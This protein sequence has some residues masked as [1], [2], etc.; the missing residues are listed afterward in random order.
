[1]SGEQHLGWEALERVRT[2]EAS[3]DEFAHLAK[4]AACRE[5]L[6][7]LERLASRFKESLGAEADAIPASREDAILSAAR[8]RAAAIAGKKLV[9]L[10]WWRQRST[11]AIA[12][13]LMVAGSAAYLTYFKGDEPSPRPV[14]TPAT[15]N[16]VE[17]RAQSGAQADHVSLRSE[18]RARTDEDA[19]P[20]KEAALLDDRP[21]AAPQELQK[22]VPSAALLPSAKPVEVPQAAA[23]PKVGVDFF[24]GKRDEA[25]SKDAKL[26]ARDSGAA[27]PAMRAPVP[28]PAKSAPAAPPAAIAD[29]RVRALADEAPAPAGSALGGAAA[30]VAGPARQAPAPPPPAA[31]EDKLVGALSAREEGAERRIAWLPP[32]TGLWVRGQGDERD[33]LE[34]QPLQLVST[35]IEVR[36]GD[37]VARRV[38]QR[39]TNPSGQP[40][41]ATYSTGLAPGESS[42]Q[43]SLKIGNS[44]VPPQPADEMTHLRVWQDLPIAGATI[45]L[46]TLSPPRPLEGVA[47]GTVRVRIPVP[48]PPPQASDTPPKLA[49]RL[50]PAQGFR[51]GQP[52]AAGLAIKGHPLG[53]GAWDLTLPPTLGVKEDILELDVPIVKSGG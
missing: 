19:G 36:V 39:F 25:A 38:R 4:C 15:R 12:A 17:Q 34:P 21:V 35:E 11:M 37:T 18:E 28:E 46:T 51:I 2:D 26:A 43:V 45:D 41:V 1:M 9:R 27:A 30:G 32:R 33:L 53:S 23:K 52:A 50:E 42:A 20:K 22:S 14:A 49:I 31:A 44:D 48:P 5:A 7:D 6:A 3:A 29:S 24:E 8:E 16:E 40:I 10:P 13:S 47:T